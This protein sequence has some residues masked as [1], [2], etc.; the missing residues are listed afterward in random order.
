MISGYISGDTANCLWSLPLVRALGVQR[1]CLH[2]DGRYRLA[3]A[4]ASPFTVTEA[5]SLRP[6]LQA[7]PY[8]QEICLYAGEPVA[9]DLDLFRYASD[10]TYHN[11][12]LCMLETFGRDPRWQAEPWLF[13]SPEPAEGTVVV[14]RNRQYPNPQVNWDELLAPYHG[15]LVFVGAPEDHAAF[16]REVRGVAEVP[17]YET[18]DLLE[19]AQLIAGCRMFIGT[20]GPIHAIAEGL[21]KELIQVVCERC[22]N[23]IFHRP[24][25]RYVPER[26]MASVVP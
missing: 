24:S 7:Q 5:S 15:T 13:V 16:V 10:L 21:K 6:L 23:S 26:F 3:V 11:V 19:V 2:T 4:G 9:Y 12:A 1:L 22:P 20:Q 8:L 25:A 18:H 14:H 17:F